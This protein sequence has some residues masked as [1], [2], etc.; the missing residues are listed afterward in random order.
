VNRKVWGGNRTWAGAE[1]Q[2]ILMSVIRTCE[3]LAAE[4][5]AFLLNALCRPQP[6]LIPA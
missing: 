5:F 3:L 2:S 1:A 4:P 6:Q